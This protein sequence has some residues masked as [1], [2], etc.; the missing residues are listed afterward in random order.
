MC[1]SYQQQLNDDSD[2]DQMIP[3]EGMRRTI[4]QR[5]QSSYQTVPHIYLTCSV[6]MTSMEALKLVLNKRKMSSE[7][8]HITLTALLTKYTACALKRHLILNS[9]LNEDVIRVKKDINIGMAVAMENGLIVPVIKNADQ[10]SLDEISLEVN[11]LTEKA[12]SSTLAPSDVAGGTFTISNLGPFGV[13][14]FTAII[15]P[16]QTSVLAVGAVIPQPVAFNQQ[17]VIRSQMKLTLAV[18]H[19]VVDGA[20]AAQFLMELKSIL[21][22]PAICEN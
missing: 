15:N 5:M 7:I 16:G 11:Q 18:D 17:V 14:E 3:L 2:Q 4:A 19:R 1:Y 13:E 20:L 9:S 22:N 8:P 6:D 21:E 10:K 12:R